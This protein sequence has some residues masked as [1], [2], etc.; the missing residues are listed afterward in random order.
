MVDSAAVQV[1][2]TF[3][4]DFFLGPGDVSLDNN[5]SGFAE[6][7]NRYVLRKSDLEFALGRVSEKRLA[8]IRQEL[9]GESGADA[10]IEPGSLLWF[11][12]QMEVETG[13]YFASGSVAGLLETD[14]AEPVIVAPQTLHD[15]L[16]VLPLVPPASPQDMSVETVLARTVPA[17][18]LLPMAAAGAEPAGIPVLLF[19]VRQGRIVGARVTGADITVQ[20]GEAGVLHISGVCGFAAMPED[21]WIFRWQTDAWSVAPLPGQYGFEDGV[22]W[23]SFPVDG[24][25]DPAEGELVIR[26]LVSS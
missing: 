10:D 26:V 3:G 20:T 23:A 19:T 8:R 21:R 24:L 1:V 15:D 17:D 2:Q 5:V 9:D 14:P 7:W 18:E 25:R 11:F 22:F 13:F 6:C 16:K 4:D 12:R